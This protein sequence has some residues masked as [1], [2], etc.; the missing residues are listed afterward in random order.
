[1]IRD[2][3]HDKTELRIF[4]L[5]PSFLS[6]R[7]KPGGAKSTKERRKWHFGRSILDN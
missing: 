7:G 6:A 4:G 5:P 3:P 2:A 1:M